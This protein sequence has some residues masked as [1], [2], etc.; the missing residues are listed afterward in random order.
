MKNWKIFAWIWGII[1]L[2]LM[3]LPGYRFPSVPFAFPGIDKLIHAFVF[4]FW[5]FCLYRYP[6]N[7]FTVIFY[8]LLYSGLTE[9]GQA[10]LFIQ[11]TADPF[12]HMANSVGGLIGL[13]LS[14]ATTKDKPVGHDVPNDN[15]KNNN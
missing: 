3:G 2:L 10:Y 8:C 6:I 4:A 14:I 1:M 11:R 12:D 5:A 15:Q 7:K 9:L 13:L